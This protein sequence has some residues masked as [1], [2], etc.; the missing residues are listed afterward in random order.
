[1]NLPTD[2]TDIKIS[3]MGYSVDDHSI[4]L[5]V[6][7]I[8][9]LNM[10]EA[11]STVSYNKILA[12]PIPIAALKPGANTITGSAGENPRHNRGE[13][14]IGAGFCF[15]GTYRASVCKSEIG[16]EKSYA[17]S[18]RLPAIICRSIHSY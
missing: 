1:L 7:G 5:T 15:Q 12:T 17:K 11:S 4:G 2:A 13:G 8:S 18:P 16:M 3:L 9:I 10:T 6:N 14:H